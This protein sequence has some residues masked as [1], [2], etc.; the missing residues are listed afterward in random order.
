MVH[1][2]SDV[3]SHKCTRP[4]CVMVR[5][6]YQSDVCTSLTF[7]LVRRLWFGLEIDVDGLP[8]LP[9]QFETW[10]NIPKIQKN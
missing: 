7:V 6:L 8:P 4:T 3:L 2:K 5:R 9:E 1:S 10:F